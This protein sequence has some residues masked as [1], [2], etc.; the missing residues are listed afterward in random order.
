MNFIR[1]LTIVGL[2][3]LVSWIPVATAAT[4][5]VPTE[6]HVAIVKMFMIYMFLPGILCTVFVSE[7]ERRKDIKKGAAN[8]SI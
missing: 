2:T 6:E 4:L 7:W 5:F 1:I 8:G 3:L